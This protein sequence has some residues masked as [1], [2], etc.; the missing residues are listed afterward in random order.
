M[1]SVSTAYTW[2]TPLKYLKGL[3]PRRAEILQKEANLATCGD[4]LEYYP[5]KYL[6]YTRVTPIAQA[7][8]EQEQVFRGRLGAFRVRISPKRNA[9]I[10]TTTLYDG[11]AWMELIWYHHWHWVQEQFTENQHVLV[12]GKPT[13]KGNTLQL[14]HPEILPLRSD[15]DIQK[16]LAVYPVYPLTEGLRKAGLTHKRFR[17]IFQELFQ[18]AHLELNDPIPTAIR[19]RYNLMEVRE[20]YRAMHL[21]T[22]LEEANQAAHRFK[23]QEFFLLQVLLA[24]RKRLL[25]SEYT[26]PAFTQVG[27]LVEVF[28]HKHLPFALTEAQ[29]RVIRELRRDMGQAVPMNRLIQGDVG[30][31]KTIVAL[32]A[33]LIAVGNGYQV[34]LMAPTEVL[35]EQHARAFRQ[36]L[37]PM[38]IAVGLLTGG[39]AAAQRKRILTQLES[40]ELPIIIG[41]HALF[42]ENVR[43]ARLGLTIIDEQHKFGV[44]QRALLWEKAHPH[45]PHNLLMTAT[46]I[47][48]TLALSLYGD[49]DVS[50]IDELPPGRQPIKTSVYAYHQRQ[51]AWRLLAEELQKGRQ[52]YIIYPLVEESEKLDLQAV[53]VGYQEI[54]KAF[55]HYKVG[56][57]HGKMSSERKEHEMARFKSGQTQILVGTTVIEV[58]VDVPNATVLIVEHADRFGLSQLHQL[59]G[60]VGRGKHASYAI[61]IASRDLSEQAMERLRA[62]QTYQDGFRISE[63]DLKLRGPGDFLGTKQSGLPEFRIADI[64]E[65][66]EILR[67]AREAAFTLI[68]ED[69]H[70]QAHPALQTYLHHYIK[71]YGL[72]FFTT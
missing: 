28:Y 41:T 8:L 2:N 11:T 5:R 67:A 40:G 18:H 39:I 12:I 37:A 3:G 72:E 25:K 42:Q 61:F 30:S 44:R 10:L 17:M 23:F 36:W 14:S 1:A 29:K 53:E 48:R 56:M 34:A 60:R 59:R 26:A 55:P 47:P 68:E 27:P 66:G 51:Q 6:D 24:Q 50:I 69:P 35:A 63:I 33:A 65:D 21:P 32:F 57:I 43:Y 58:G 13:Y 7:L 16:L 52:A 45:R 38:G 31:G 15:T 70:L 62:L 64:V 19:D 20:A 49:V 22:S 71:Q 9:S 54:Q 46:P 4:L